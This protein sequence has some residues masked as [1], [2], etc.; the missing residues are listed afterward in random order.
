MA[1]IG[2]D[3][4][5]KRWLRPIVRVRATQQPRRLHNLSKELPSMAGVERFQFLK[6]SA[7]NSLFAIAPAKFP[8]ATALATERI[9]MAL[10]PQA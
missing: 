4:L 3:S 8:V 10:S 9:I 6:S 7:V 5:T 2:Y 1:C